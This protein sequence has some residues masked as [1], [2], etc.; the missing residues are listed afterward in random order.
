MAIKLTDLR[1][2]TSQFSKKRTPNCSGS[3]LRAEP[4]RSR[5]LF[6]V[7]CNESYS[8][9]PHV[10]RIKALP[11]E[12]HQLRDREVAVTCS[13]PFWVYWGP[14]YNAAQGGFSEA[15]RSNGA[16]PDIRDPSRQNLICKHVWV[17]GRDA[18]RFIVPDQEKAKERI[19]RRKREDEEKRLFRER[20]EQRQEEQEELP[21]YLL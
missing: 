10:V 14:D 13:C 16:P 12:E 5:W 19:E 9:G 3:M 15:I 17:A 18:E 7:K 1:N 11:G 20:R 21:E 2:Q 8:K 4:S 6:R